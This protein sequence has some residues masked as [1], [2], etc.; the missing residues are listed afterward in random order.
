MYF[1]SV[2]VVETFTPAV[3]SAFRSTC[4]F[5]RSD[6]FLVT[7]FHRFVFYFRLIVPTIKQALLKSALIFRHLNLVSLGL[8][9]RLHH[10]FRIY[11]RD[12]TAIFS[13][14]A[15]IWKTLNASPDC[16]VLGHRQNII[17]FSSRNLL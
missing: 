15:R 13:V 10:I 4:H 3:S 11:S 8:P 12:I 2:Y 14:T 5:R 17:L 16:L 1:P 6:S 9:H 7:I